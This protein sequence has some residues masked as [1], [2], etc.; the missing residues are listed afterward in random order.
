MY[1]VNIFVQIIMQQNGDFML[2]LDMIDYS[3]LNV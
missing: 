2:K 1:M 3:S